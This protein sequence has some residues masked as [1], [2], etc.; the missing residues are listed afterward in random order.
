MTVWIWIRPTVLINPGL[1]NHAF[2]TVES[3]KQKQLFPPAVSDRSFRSIRGTKDHSYKKKALRII[4]LT[5]EEESVKSYL[6]SLQIL[7][8]FSQYIWDNQFIE[9]WAT[10]N[11]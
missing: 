1:L 11:I 9:K 7:T 8:V 10:K 3:C 6:G 5:N 4:I 2:Y